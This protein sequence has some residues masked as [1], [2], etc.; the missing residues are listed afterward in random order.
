M[1]DFSGLGLHASLIRGFA[2][3]GFA[4][5]TE[6]QARAIPALLAGRDL[7]M[8]SET[9]TGKTFAYL[10]PVLQAIAEG[11]AADAK[12][13]VALV[14]APTQELAVQIG[15]EAGKLAAASGVEAPVEVL[16]GGSPIARQ[17]VQ[18]RRGPRIVV[19]T[20][21]RLSDLAFARVLKLGRLRF[22]I[23]DEADRLLA[24]ETE[25]LC[26]RLVEAVPRSAQRV[27]ASA[28]LPP[29]TRT[30]A[31][32]WLRD[33][34]LVEAVAADV[35]S[36]DIEH[37]CF[38]CDTRKRLDFVRRFEAAAAPRRCLLFHSNAA[39]LGKLL[40]T[41][42]SFGLPIAAIS[43]RRDK[44]ERRVALE[45]FAG[46]SLRYLL[47]SDLGARGLDIAGID[48]VISLDLPEEPT[49]Y[50]HRAGRTG[51]AGSKGVSIVLADSVELKR[52]SRLA[53]RGD[54]VFRTK[55]LREGRIFEPPVEEFFAF[56]EESEG[57][58]DRARE[59]R[60]SD[61]KDSRPD[62]R[63]SVE[64]REERERKTGKGR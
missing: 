30:I 39:R 19:G 33:P 18:L 62:P 50:I 5:P 51:R 43:S 56:V 24:K 60:K 42:E 23:L 32:P 26:I 31:A 38:Y 61:A 2:A 4:Q 58:R 34:V 44:E 6:V 41:L 52:A 8:E 54:F 64:R 20:L 3:L 57:K 27:L 11:P 17:E 7:L 1:E 22:L 63:R 29:R 25:E 21:G 37:W 45:R 36:G 40:E 28:T 35:L 49:V 46:G 12:G 13:I 55:I 15:R 47:T 48:H 59:E 16:L 53:V 14:A 10:A 9:G